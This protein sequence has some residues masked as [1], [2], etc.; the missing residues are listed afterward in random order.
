VIRLLDPH[1]III[2]QH[3]HG[4]PPESLIDQEAEVVEPHLAVLTHDACHLT[5]LED[6][7][8]MAGID[9]TPFGTS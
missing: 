8:E 5:E 9:R 3:L 7:P 4:L 2:D 1:R 6:A